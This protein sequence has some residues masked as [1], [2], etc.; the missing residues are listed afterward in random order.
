MKEWWHNLAENERKMVMIGGILATILLFYALIW[1][2]LKK[3][4]TSQMRSLDNKNSLLIWMQNTIKKLHA[5]PSQ[6]LQS[7]DRNNILG[8]VINSLKSANLYP[9][10]QQIQQV[11]DN[12][13]QLTFNKVSFDDFISWL[14]MLQ[15]HYAITIKQANF[16]PLPDSGM[17]KVSLILAPR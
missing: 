9:L 13:A 15:Q 16:N 3:N 17:V 1:I 4:V 6:H 14:T 8:L 11:N 2:P 7:V 10:L 5:N 12:N